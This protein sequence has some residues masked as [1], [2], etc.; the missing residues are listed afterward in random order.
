MIVSN[1][2]MIY[3]PQ[4]QLD[5]TSERELLNAS[6]ETDLRYLQGLTLRPGW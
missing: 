1:D 4:R 3:H 5:D 2:L 6:I